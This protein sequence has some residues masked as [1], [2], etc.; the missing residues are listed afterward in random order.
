V[1]KQNPERITIDLELCYENANGENRRDLSNISVIEVKRSKGADRSDMIDVLRKYK[2]GS[3]G[4]SKY[5]M[6]TVLT[7]ENV[8]TNLFRKRIRRLGKIEKNFL[9]N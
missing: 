4:F 2:I 3:M 1:H 5:C 7:Q 8:K 6:G 9:I